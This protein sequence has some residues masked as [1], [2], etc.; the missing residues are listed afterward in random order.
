MSFLKGCR[1]PTSKGFGYWDEAFIIV[2][3]PETPIVVTSVLFSNGI[4]QLYSSELKVS[5]QKHAEL[6]KSGWKPM[7]IEDLKATSGIEGDCY[8]Y[9]EY[10]KKRGIAITTLGVVGMVV[11]AYVIRACRRSHRKL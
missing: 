10:K 5:I 6:L 4:N 2:I 7:C 11:G 1:S 8:D 9:A 3:H